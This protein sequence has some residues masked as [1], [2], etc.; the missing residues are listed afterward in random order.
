MSRAQPPDSSKPDSSGNPGVPDKYAHKTTGFGVPVTTS[1]HHFIVTIPRGSR[2]A[3]SISED[4]GMHA[5]GEDSQV[6]DRVVLNRQLWTEIA[7]PV[8]RLFNQRL[9]ANNLAVSNWKVGKNPVDRL[10]GKELCVLAW[11]VEGLP[12][13]RAGI[14]LRNWLEL[15]PEERW[16]LFGMTAESVGAP[17]DKGKGWRAALVHALGYSPDKII[18]KPRQ[19]KNEHKPQVKSRE[20]K[21][22]LLDSIKNM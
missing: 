11:A 17:E 21:R 15:R 6:L 1:P 7:N 2:Q 13:D 12:G 14:A 4:L 9:K 5:L 20:I 3:V 22:S 19:V 10:L 18:R 16:W 8:K